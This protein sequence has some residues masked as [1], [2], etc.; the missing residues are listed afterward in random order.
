MICFDGCN[1]SC[2]LKTRCKISLVY[3]SSTL[4]SR[5]KCQAK[6]VKWGSLSAL[7]SRCKIHGECSSSTL[8][9][10]YTISG[11]FAK[12]A[13]NCDLLNNE[14][15]T[16]ITAKYKKIRTQLSTRQYI[17]STFEGKKI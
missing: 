5:C 17:L 3:T 6:F 13:I 12:Y 7:K 10:R 16:Q 15:L 1:T 8:K 4:N 11:N 2:T 9:T 14:G